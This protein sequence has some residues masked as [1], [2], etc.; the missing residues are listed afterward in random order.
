MV[1]DLK[2]RNWAFVYYGTDQDVDAVADQ[3]G[4]SRTNREYYGKEEITTLT[5]QMM[6][7]RKTVSD[8]IRRGQNPDADLLSD[9]K[10][11]YEKKKK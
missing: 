9:A 3:I 2:C 4:F 5:K 10:Q 7:T 1:E 6:D 8:K 11:A